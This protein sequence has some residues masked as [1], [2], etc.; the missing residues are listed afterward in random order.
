MGIY[1]NFKNHYQQSQR[2]RPRPCKYLLR[3][4]SNRGIVEVLKLRRDYVGISAFSCVKTEVVRCAAM[5]RLKSSQGDPFEVPLSVHAV[6]MGPL[7]IGPSKPPPQGTFLD[8]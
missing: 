6:F 7:F 5:L 4:D 2:G 8:R 1:R 3:G